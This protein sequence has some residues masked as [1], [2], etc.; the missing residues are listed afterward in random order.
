MLKEGGRA[1][2]EFQVNGC[3]PFFNI[4]TCYSVERKVGMGTP[5]PPLKGRFY[6]PTNHTDKRQN[7]ADESKILSVGSN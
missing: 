7:T 2:M 5:V 3:W 4:Q 6:E 1:H